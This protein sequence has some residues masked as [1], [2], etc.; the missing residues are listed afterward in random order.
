MPL[1]YNQPAGA[2]FPTFDNTV[3]KSLSEKRPNITPVRL[4]TTRHQRNYKSGHLTA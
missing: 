1:A 3:T 2:G 4:V